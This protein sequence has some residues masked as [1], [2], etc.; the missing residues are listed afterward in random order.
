MTGI[1]LIKNW[2]SQHSVSVFRTRQHLHL[3]RNEGASPWDLGSSDWKDRRHWDHSPTA[4]TQKPQNHGHKRPSNTE[5]FPRQR[6]DYHSWER[7]RSNVNSRQAAVPGG[8]EAQTAACHGQE[9]SMGYSLN[10]YMSPLDRLEACP[11]SGWGSAARSGWGSGSSYSQDGWSRTAEPNRYRNRNRDHPFRDPQRGYCNQQQQHSWRRPDGANPHAIGDG[12]RNY[13]DIPE[14]F[15]DSHSFLK[16]PSHRSRHFAK[17]GSSTW[18]RSDRGRADRDKNWRHGG[19]VSEVHRGPW[20]GTG[21]E[22]HRQGGQSDTGWSSWLVGG[23]GRCLHYVWQ[24]SVWPGL[25]LRF[26]RLRLK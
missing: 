20:R 19:S 26:F 14:G 5:H 13:R 6:R 21:A 16:T 4:R 7:G 11:Q 18:N 2:Q 22:G 3:F 9:R 1:I 25:I 12:G 24:P 10:Q 8:P 23:L 17:D 15:Q